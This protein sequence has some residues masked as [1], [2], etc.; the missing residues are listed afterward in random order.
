MITT[1]IL[2]KNLKGTKVIMMTQST[3]IDKCYLD[4]NSNKT[5]IIFNFLIIKRRKNIHWL[6]A[7]PTTYREITIF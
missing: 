3:V 2:E 6:V 5:S 1:L 4:I 7:A